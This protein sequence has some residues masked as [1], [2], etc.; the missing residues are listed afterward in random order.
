MQPN[1]DS[2]RRQTVMAAG[3]RR[4]TDQYERRILE[5]AQQRLAVVEGRLGELRA[6]SL[7]NT[8]HADEYMALTTERGQLQQVIATSKRHLGPASAGRDGTVQPSD[9]SL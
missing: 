6:S 1:I 5:T 3:I 7:T 8:S 9:G 2:V 4:Q